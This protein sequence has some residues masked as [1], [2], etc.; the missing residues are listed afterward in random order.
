MRDGWSILQDRLVMSYV[1]PKSEQWNGT[2]AVIRAI[3]FYAHTENGPF[4][5]E[6]S[7]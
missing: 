6:S 4:L 1:V 2:V 3:A 5:R 7:V